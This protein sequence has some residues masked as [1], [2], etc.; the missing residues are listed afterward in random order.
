MGKRL[1]Y[2]F[3]ILRPMDQ[4]TLEQLLERLKSLEEHRG[5]DDETVQYRC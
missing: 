3:L 1:V 2:L 5:G 4:D